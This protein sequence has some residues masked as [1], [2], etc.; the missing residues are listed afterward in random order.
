MNVS[1]IPTTFNSYSVTTATPVY[2][3]VHG[4]A[5]PMTVTAI[6]G[7]SG[8]LSVFYSTT[9]GAAQNPGSANWLAWTAGTVSANTTDGLLAPVCALKFTA[10]TSTGTVEVV[11]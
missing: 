7:A 11:S 8:S 9:N 3:D 10:A 2:V 1:Q 5:F 6:P 4:S